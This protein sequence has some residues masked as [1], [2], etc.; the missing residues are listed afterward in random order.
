MRFVALTKLGRARLATASLADVGQRR[1]SDVAPRSLQLSG[2]TPD[3]DW[4]L[5]TKRI[6]NVMSM[7]SETAR[8]RFDPD[9]LET[10][11]SPD[12]AWLGATI[13]RM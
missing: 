9:C 6:G 8:Y 10:P 7:I 2:Q 3:L 13:R 4:L 12:N 11:C 1:R 5:L